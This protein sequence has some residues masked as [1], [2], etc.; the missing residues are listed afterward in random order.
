MV[1]TVAASIVVRKLGTAAISR[2]ELSQ[3]LL[4]DVPEA[5]LLASWESA[6]RTVENWRKHGASVVFTNGCFD[7]LHPGH[8]ALIKGAAAEGDK[9]IV[10][11]N[12]DAS[13]KRLKGEDLHF[14]SL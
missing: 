2:E 7:L 13:V 1:A 3:Q 12:S 11:I 14:Q 4:K 9:L 6:A 10:A 8:I 5:G